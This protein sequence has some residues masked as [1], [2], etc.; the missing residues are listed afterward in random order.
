MSIDIR[1]RIVC[2]SFSSLYSKKEVASCLAVSLEH[3]LNG[4][5]ID[6]ASIPI[7]EGLEEKPS[8]V[9]VSVNFPYYG[10]GD[11]YTISA[12]E[13]LSGSHGN[14]FIPVVSFDKFSVTNFSINEL[15]SFIKRCKLAIN[16]EM[17][18]CLE[19][20]W[21][22]NEDIY[23][24]IC[25]IAEPYEGA[26]L[27]I[28]S[29]SKKPNKISDILDVGKRLSMNSACSYDYYGAIPAKKEG[30]VEI[31]SA[32]FSN[33]GVPKHMLSSII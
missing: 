28:S 5:L 23:D 16:G 17:I 13:I 3:E 32:G 1:D 10:L 18:F 2:V 7:L 8:K 30:V 14:N 19:L 20:S 6:L 11:T 25:S 29:F 26:R 4:C 31:L 15:R 9:Y 24:K 27:A 33:V 21:V 12:L 22:N